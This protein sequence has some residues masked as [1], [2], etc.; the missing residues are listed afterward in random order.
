MPHYLTRMWFGCEDGIAAV[1]YGPN[2]VKTTINGV[3]VE[4]E[5]ATAY[6][7]KN[8]V[9]F[10]INPQQAV[11]FTLYLRKP[12]WS[13][14]VNFTNF[15]GDFTIEEKDGF[16][17][18]RKQWH[19]GD[20]FEMTFSPSISLRPYPNGENSI[21]Y[22]PLQFVL[23]IETHFTPTKD[24]TATHLHD[25]DITPASLEQAYKIIMLDAAQPDYGLRVEM[26]PETSSDLDWA[27]PGV[28]L[29]FGSE[30]L[31][32]LGSTILR[33]AAFPLKAL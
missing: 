28:S 8:K 5:E 14:E 20:K 32:P 12:A 27:N 7:F 29:W 23:P 31:L 9:S 26:L 11:E 4:I 17:A 25:Y 3:A 24:Y 15:S 16:F 21:F 30:K 33:R 2:R 19:P 18:L 22:G 6:P 13:P 10:T 1:T